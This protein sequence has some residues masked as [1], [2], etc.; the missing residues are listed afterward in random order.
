MNN[1]NTILSQILQFIPEYSLQK[2]VTRY[3]TDKYSKTFKTKHL[4]TC[5]I[6]AHASGNDTLRSIETGLTAL[7]NHH[8]HLGL[9]STGIKRSTLADANNRVD[10]HVFEDL[11]YDLLSKYQGGFYKEDLKIKHP[12]YAVDASFIDVIID[13]FPWAKYRATKGAIKM[14]A[15]INVEQFLPT[16]I[17]ITTGKIHDLEGMP[18]LDKDTYA[19]SIITFDKGYWKASM[20]SRLNNDGIYFVTRIKTNVTYNV[21]GQ[22]EITLGTGVI[23]DEEIEFK[24]D[25]LQE[26]YPG[27]LRLVTY[28]D[29]EH[30]ITY[31]FVTNIFHLSAELIA[32]IYKYRWK[33]ETFFRWIKQN[34]KIKSF[35]GCSENAVM[36]QI[37]IGMIYYLLLSHIKSQCNYQYTRLELTRVLKSTLFQKIPLINLMRADFISLKKNSIESPDQLGFD[38]S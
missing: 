16:L 25:A 36:S 23:K 26:D 10:Y 18:Y 15:V 28:H 20:L 22:H 34:L 8:Y 14:H 35:L 3:Q 6:Y 29:R 27:T 17:N 24:T 33:I 7:S 19:D 32:K 5:M 2:L 37:W 21:T 31:Q 4:L 12:L 9:P 30:D 38:S 11:F 1:N 13:M